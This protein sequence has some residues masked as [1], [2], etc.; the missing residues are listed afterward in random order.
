MNALIPVR[1]HLI[2]AHPV[3]SVE[4]RELHG[5]LEVGKDFSNWI[6]D[7]IEQYGFAED[8]DYALTVA[9]TGVRQNVIQKDYFLTLDMAKE[10]AMVERNERGR[11]ARR[12]F[13][14]C[15]RRLWAGESAPVSGPVSLS[16]LELAHQRLRE[17]AAEPDPAIRHQLWH[18]LHA[19]HTSLGLPPPV[20]ALRDTP[21]PP[22]PL[23]ALPNPPHPWQW[24]LK[25]LLREVNGG[26]YAGPYAYEQIDGRR[27][28][29]FR[30]G[31]LLAH[32]QRIPA[33]DLAWR[34]HGGLTA[35]LFKQA[36]IRQGLLGEAHF[37]RNLLGRRINHL[38][39]LDL[40]APPAALQGQPA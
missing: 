17:L 27:V 31:D 15:E 28:L 9:K 7:R 22:S 39:A 35:R 5:F 3:P 6:K 30:P 25:T 23:P 38:Q 14:E 13:I 20:T 21:P 18:Y 24:L 26:R 34:E 40:A 8:L 37:E 36:L 16:G 10:L 4:A 2:G 32:L 1:E 33:L 19:L 12:Y 11:Q 29:L